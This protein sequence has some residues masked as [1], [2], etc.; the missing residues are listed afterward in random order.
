MS[1]SAEL[2]DAVAGASKVA[3]VHEPKASISRYRWVVLAVAFS[4]FLVTFLD[5]LAWATANLFAGKSLEIPIAAL[6]VFVTAF[7]VG[8][9]TA[10]ALAGFVTDRVGPRLMLF[11]ALAPLAAST[12]LFGLTTS[13]ATGLAL[14]G[15]MGLCAGA[16]YAACVK[17]VA[18]WFPR[19]ERGRAFGLFSMAPSIGVAGANA[20]FPGLLNLIDWRTLYWG[21][22]GLT[23]LVAAICLWLLTD[24]PTER[25]DGVRSSPA[26]PATWR[27]G[28]SALCKDRNLVLI[29]LA[30][31]GANWGTWGFAFW[32]T[33]LM[34]RGYQLSPTDAGVVALIFG[35]AAAVS[36]P[37]YGLLSDMLGGKRRNL[38]I[39]DL[40]AFAAMLMLFGLMQTK[41]G[42]LLAAPF[43]GLTAVVYS[44]L[45]AA[46]I[47]ERIDL[48]FTASATGV[49]NAFWQLGSVI[50]PTIVGV[51]FAATGSFSIA[52]A[53]LAAGPL[54][55]AFCMFAVS[56]EVST[57]HHRNR[58]AGCV[59]EKG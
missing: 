2:A 56:E 43:L 34:V 54:I 1:V 3:S 59:S 49:I 15:L 48:R 38:I 24:S 45:L 47:T 33:A 46:M 7:Y 19:A 23:A 13:F 10:S 28:L 27:R 39:Y 16:D 5:R 55:G 9:V 37:L 35:I 40:I 53:I 8:Y 17:V 51:V 12:F 25:D 30:G 31:F 42:F 26:D 52:F 11:F 18:S 14:Q 36:K 32:A 41:A 20:I 4:A 29:A 44:P 58:R 21:L 57:V 22:G 6:G 50:V